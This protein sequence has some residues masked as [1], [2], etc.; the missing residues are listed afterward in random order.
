M[1]FFRSPSYCFSFLTLPDLDGIGSSSVGLLAGLLGDGP[2]VWFPILDRSTV[3][4]TVP[5]AGLQPSDP[6]TLS[7]WRSSRD[8]A[9]ALGAAVR[10]TTTACQSTRY[11]GQGSA[12][13]QIGPPVARKVARPGAT[14]TNRALVDPSGERVAPRAARNRPAGSSPTSDQRMRPRP[15]S[16]TSTRPPTPTS[17]VRPSEAVVSTTGRGL[18]PPSAS[19]EVGE[20]AVTRAQVPA[21]SAASPARARAS[22][23]GR[24]TGG[25]GRPEVG[26]APPALRRPQRSG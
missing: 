16:T 22:R 14:A 19:G 8:G 17:V 9:T 24:L 15:A 25:T 3:P 6:E 12:L 20:N 1:P 18:G 13:R 26:S 23:G 10:T 11:S 21:N 4:S 5:R 7:S 2:P